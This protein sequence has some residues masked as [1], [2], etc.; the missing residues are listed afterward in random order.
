MKK[1]LLLALVLIPLLALAQGEDKAKAQ[2]EP[3]LVSI[4]AKATD[5]RAIIADLFT[6]AKLNYV[7]Q[8]GAQASL[9]LTLDKIEF[10]EALNIICAQSKLQFE[11]QN[12]IYFITRAKPAVIAPAIPVIK[13]I[14]P[15][16]VLQKQLTTKLAKTDIRLVFAAFAKQTHVTIEVDKSVPNYKLDAFLTKS[17]LA[18]SLQKVTQATGLKFRFT[19]RLSIAIYK[20]EDPN[21]VSISNG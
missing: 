10:E 13:G 19:D 8:P 16:S 18:V 20:P 5:V 1:A 15:K 7:L 14:L 17:T 9:F 11:I 3:V 21:K 4:S 2:K 6:Q 12:G